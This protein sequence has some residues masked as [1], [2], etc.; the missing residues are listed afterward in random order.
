MKKKW[1]K[2]KKKKKKTLSLVKTRIEFGEVHSVGMY[3]WI[4]WFS[5]D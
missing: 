2:W 3:R 5:I 1:E 4:G